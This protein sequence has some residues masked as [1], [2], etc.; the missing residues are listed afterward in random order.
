MGTTA[1]ATTGEF[2]VTANKAVS[3]IPAGALVGV[4]INL[5]LDNFANVRQAVTEAASSQVIK[6]AKAANREG[7]NFF[8]S[9]SGTN[10]YAAAQDLYTIQGLSRFGYSYPIVTENA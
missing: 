5:N 7:T 1:D 8:P 2:D 3:G 10:T 4:G 6:I 9:A